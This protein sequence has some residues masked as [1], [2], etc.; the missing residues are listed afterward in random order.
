MW[1]SR[2]L[3]S[4]EIAEELGLSSRTV[5]GLLDRGRRTLDA[6]NRPHAVAEAI[7]LGLIPPV[8]STVPTLSARQQAVADEVARGRTAADIAENLGISVGTVNS[9]ILAARRKSGARTSSELAAIIASLRLASAPGSPATTTGPNSP[10]VHA[11]QGADTQPAGWTFASPKARPESAARP[12]PDQR[13]LATGKT[14]PLVSKALQLTPEA[15]PEAEE[16]A[17]RAV[18]WALDLLREDERARIHAGSQDEIAF[19]A[20]LTRAS[21][22]EV[23]RARM[24]AVLRG[25]IKTRLTTNYEPLSFTQATSVAASAGLDR[26]LFRNWA[27]RSL[28]LLPLMHA[29]LVAVD[30]QP[31]LAAFTFYSD[32]ATVSDATAYGLH[33]V[34]AKTSVSRLAGLAGLGGDVVVPHSCF[35]YTVGLRDPGEAPIGLQGLDQFGVTSRPLSHADHFDLLLRI[36]TAARG[37]LERARDGSRVC[38]GARVDPSVILSRAF[39]RWLTVGSLPFGV[40]PYAVPLPAATY[41]PGHDAD[42][43]HL[44]RHHGL[45]P[46]YLLFDTTEMAASATAVRDMVVSDGETVYSGGQFLDLLCAADRP[47]IRGLWQE[48]AQALRSLQHLPELAELG[49]H[50][51]PEHVDWLWQARGVRLL[52]GNGR[53]L[54]IG[55]LV[56]R[57]PTGTRGYAV[58]SDLDNPEWRA[59][60][61]GRA[62]LHTISECD[63]AHSYCISRVFDDYQLHSPRSWRFDTRSW[64]RLAA[65]LSNTSLVDVGRRLQARQQRLVTPPDRVFNGASTLR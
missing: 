60:A 32:T 22:Y 17:E 55:V 3:D 4:A 56:R 43:L 38:G 14:R 26:D 46:L 47:A 1:A 27:P 11:E 16:Q 52:D 19:G 29:Y 2:G 41:M 5:E 63:T 58:R 59:Y 57:T 45:S 31:R 7:N 28:L 37:V 64:L 24:P 42:L 20:W 44:A 8:T 62:E 53:S 40:D 23:L 51:D 18:L 15:L 54:P 34:S 36:A 21:V 39:P 9:H 33:R 61:I 65:L 30:A 10:L 25:L 49:V 50:I 6:D 13:Q 12:Y 35:P 48:P